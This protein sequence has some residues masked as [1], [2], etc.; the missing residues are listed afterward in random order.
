MLLLLLYEEIQLVGEI[1]H[2][3]K[4]AKTHLSEQTPS[5]HSESREAVTQHTAPP[6]PTPPTAPLYFESKKQKTDPLESTSIGRE[7]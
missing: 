5:V 6:Q 4:S 3:Q 1:S 2:T 7:K